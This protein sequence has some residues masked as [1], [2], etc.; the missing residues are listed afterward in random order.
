M[1]NTRER[2]P[3]E[4]LPEDVIAYILKVVSSV[5]VYDL[6]AVK[7]C[8]APLILQCQFLNFFNLHRTSI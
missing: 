4:S 2:I 1:G 6:A 7:V 8:Y 3:L 5:F